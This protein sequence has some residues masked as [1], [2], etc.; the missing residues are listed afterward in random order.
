[1][2]LQGWKVG[3]AEAALTRAL[4][5][6]SALAAWERIT[7]AHGGDPDPDLLARPRATVEVPAPATGYVTACAGEDLGRVTAAVG[8]GRSRVDEELAH[9]AG[10]MIHARIGDRVET[11]QPLATLMLGEREVDQ[12]SLTNRIAEAFEIGPERVDPP[13]LV[14]GTADDIAE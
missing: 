14:L 4:A 12:K 10:V 1:M 7:V 13:A 9:G 2:A 5:D 3:Q 6:G 11:S 8:A